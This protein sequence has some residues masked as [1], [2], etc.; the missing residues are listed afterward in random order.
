LH[1]ASKRIPS[2]ESGAAQL[3]IQCAKRILFPGCGQF[4]DEVRMNAAL[5][6]LNGVGR[7]R[8]G[9]GSHGDRVL[10]M[11]I[12]WAAYPAADP[13]YG[14]RTRNRLANC[15]AKPASRQ[16]AKRLLA[17]RAALGYAYSNE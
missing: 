7:D 2:I 16:G 3:P 5:A 6:F 10:L 15:G 4:I 13:S 8:H 11:N 17:A 1:P 12:L 14:A 9:V